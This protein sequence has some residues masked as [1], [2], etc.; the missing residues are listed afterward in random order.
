MVLVPVIAEPHAKLRM[1]TIA[2]DSLKQISGAVFEG[3][4]RTTVPIPFL[5][6]EKSIEINDFWVITLHGWTDRLAGLP[7]SRVPGRVQNDF[8]KDPGVMQD[9]LII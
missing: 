4:F 1:I 6:S 8:S 7:K 2:E 3:T 5:D 9:F